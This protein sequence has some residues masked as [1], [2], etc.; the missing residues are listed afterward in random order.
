MEFFNS[1]EEYVLLNKNHEIA[2]FTLADEELSASM[3]PLNFTSVQAWLDSRV[4][5]SCARNVREFFN[6]IGLKTTKDLIEITHCVSL[7]D[8][9]WVKRKGSELQWEDVSPFR[10]DYSRVVSIYALE[11]VIGSGGSLFFTGSQYGWL[12]SAYMEIWQYD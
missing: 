5:F 8:T 1:L 7:S 10:H 2:T 3:L 9:F 12:F 11:G 6:T 4:K